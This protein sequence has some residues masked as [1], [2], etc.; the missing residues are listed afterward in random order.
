MTSA[1]E[2]SQ[3]L[4]Q[5]A[6]SVAKR[7]LSAGKLDDHG[8]EWAAGS[9]AGE[10]GRSLK[11]C[12]KGAKAGTWKDFAT[13]EG[14][15]L[16]DLWAAVRGI[17]L[18]DALREAKDYLGIGARRERRG[19][20]IRPAAS[21]HRESDDDAR[22]RAAALLIWSESIPLAGTLGEEYL[23]ARRGCR[24]PPSGGDLRFHP[25]LR[26]PQPRGDGREHPALVALATTVAGNQPVG[27]HRLYLEPGSP[28]ALA[29]LRLG[30]CD[31]PVCI[32]L[33]PD[34]AVTCGLGIAEG[35]ETAL[36]LAHLF[37]PVWS[38]IDAGQMAR[39]PVLAGVDALTI[40]ADNDDAG[41]RAAA[42]CFGRWRDAGR[43]VTIVRPEQT[44]ADINDVIGANA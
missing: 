37:R 28:R 44:G 39:F 22:R 8:R 20:P 30:G 34:D 26:F 13:G 23:G 35:I 38:T 6:P 11:I 4:A 21:V 41:N 40:A 27:I 32:R 5:I 10:P 14:G 2:V 17:P 36:S 19:E 3:R 15:D 18:A 16:L 12:I 42:E 7:L 43:E 33:W 29:K 1:A 9:I 24:L 25:R 31:E